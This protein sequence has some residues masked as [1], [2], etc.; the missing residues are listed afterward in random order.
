MTYGYTSLLHFDQI[1]WSLYGNTNIFMAFF[2]REEKKLP[3]NVS[4]M[5]DAPNNP[6]LISL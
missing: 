2:F 4:G 3:V 6:F 5:H 1:N